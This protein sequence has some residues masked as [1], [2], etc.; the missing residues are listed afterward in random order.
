MRILNKIIILF[1]LL[2]SITVNAQSLLDNIKN[3]KN[4]WKLI[5]WPDY[6]GFYNQIT[7]RKIDNKITFQRGA[8]FEPPKND[9][10]YMIIQSEIDCNNFLYRETGYTYFFDENDKE[11]QRISAASQKRDIW[12][13]IPMQTAIDGYR[14]KL[15]R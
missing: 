3:E 14:M 8:L 6:L 13:S 9:V 10:T 2:L 7:L 12:E 5:K 4:G 15:C 1:I 11:L